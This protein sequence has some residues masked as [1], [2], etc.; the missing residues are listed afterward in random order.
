MPTDQGHASACIHCG[1]IDLSIVSLCCKHDICKACA[2]LVETGA[3]DREIFG[4]AG[5]ENAS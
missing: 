3:L 2:K 5:G 1:S 4:Y